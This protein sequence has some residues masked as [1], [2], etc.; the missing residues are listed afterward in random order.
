MSASLIGLAVM[1][2][3]M[4]SGRPGL[5][6]ISIWIG[7]IPQRAL[8]FER[9]SKFC[10]LVRFDKRGTGLSDRPVNMA[11]LEGRTDDIRAV[12]DDVGI[13]S[14]NIFG[15]SEGGSMACPFA[16][17]YPERV[18]S[19]LIWGTQ[20]R[21]VACEDHPR[22]QTREE[23]KGKGRKGAGEKS[24]RRKRRFLLSSLSLLRSSFSLS[25]LLLALRTVMGNSFVL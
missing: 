12:M 11:T 25:S 22:A 17:T 19:L 6:R 8:F 23:H 9:F 14:A 5:C 1:D 24:N 13:K 18:D 4:L 20:A 7:E 10:R 15:V 21:W 2:H 16:A 3:S